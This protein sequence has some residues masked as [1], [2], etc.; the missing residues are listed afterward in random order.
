MSDRPTKIRFNE[1]REQVPEELSSLGEVCRLHPGSQGVLK[2]EQ[3][4]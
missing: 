4:Q 2:L 1:M 3:L